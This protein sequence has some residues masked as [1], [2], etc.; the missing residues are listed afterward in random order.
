[1]AV[2]ILLLV[3]IH[4]N[5]AEPAEECPGFFAKLASGLRYAGS[6]IKRAKDDYVAEVK[7]MGPKGVL[8]RRRSAEEKALSYSDYFF[9][10]IPKLEDGA[11]R[12]A[13]AMNKGKKLFAVKT[14][15]GHRE[16]APVIGTMD[17]IDRLFLGEHTLRGPLKFSTHMAGIL[18]T[19][20]YVYGPAFEKVLEKIG[21]W[22]N[23]DNAV[24]S[25]L[26]EGYIYRKVRADIRSGKL[27][28]QEATKLVRQDILNRQKYFSLVGMMLQNNPAAD[29]RDLAQKFIPLLSSPETRK[30]FEDLR[31]YLSDKIRKSP[32]IVWKE[33]GAPVTDEQYRELFALNHYKN[34]G[35]ASFPDWLQEGF[36]AQALE[37]REPATFAVYQELMADPFQRRLLELRKAGRISESKLEWLSLENLEWR[38]RFE[39]LGVLGASMRDTDGSAL[40]LERKRAEMLKDNNLD[41]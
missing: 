16:I 13:R 40:T 8:V 41:P 12:I 30:I 3:S 29:M 18:A 11:G 9:P 27:S 35:F 32:F 34:Y 1:M 19:F 7:E 31:F 39:A 6:S 2:I 4:A 23:F 5:A 22:T 28:R 21:E 38:T 26:E 20:G 36:D 24:N 17:A 14:K 10:K 37:A 33:P 25:G 15:T